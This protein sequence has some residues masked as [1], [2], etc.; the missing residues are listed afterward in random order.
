MKSLYKLNSM[1]NKKDKQLLLGLVFMTILLSLIEIIGIGAVMPFISIASNPNLVLENSHYKE[2]YDFFAFSNVTSFILFFGITLI[3][4][5]IFRG[6]YTIF[7]AYMLTKL[8]MGK[9]SSFSNKLFE[10]YMNMPYMEFAK[11]NSASLTKVIITEALQLSSMLRN[12]LILFSEL[13]IVVFLYIILLMID[14]N[15]TL[16]LTLLLG[17][18]IV[19]LIVT[20]TK[21][22]KVE[23]RKRASV[24]DNFYREISQMFGNFKIIKFI[25]NQTQLL[26]HFS[27]ISKNFT[28]VQVKN[29][30]LQAIPRSVLEAIG[31]SILI[32]IVIYIIYYEDDVS[33]VIPII[34]MYALALYR[35]LPAATKILKSYNNI[36]FYLSS[37][38]IVHNDLSVTYP[39]ER[40]ETINF[41]STIEINNVSFSYD[42]KNNVLEEISLVINK[43]SKVAFIG[44]SGSGKSTLVDLL[45]GIY[46]PNNGKVLID[47]KVLND[48][49]LVSWRKRIGYIPQDIYL[50][51]GTVS[52]NIVFGREYDE[53]KLMEVLKQANLYDFIVLNNGL[54][55]MVGDRGLQL[56]GGQKQRIGIARALYGKP[57]ILVLDEATSAL[58]NKTE[59]AI[60]NEIYK[61]SE[62]KTL[63]IIAHRLSTVEK[64]DYKIEIDKGKIVGK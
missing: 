63:I 56:S 43:G 2:V 33:R 4:F 49:N 20:V 34:S 31:L 46:K 32:G 60:M 28:N 36:V 64:C 51:D 47:S 6:I 53:N 26:N 37:L 55:S 42:N 1:L 45:C 5:Y 40:N 27:K 8:S 15:M 25:S 39:I 18:K 29:D 38:N 44:K 21:K 48:D 50:F 12:I 52:D 57:D 9:Y 35:I 13:L 30:T 59:T 19:F 24:Q 16:I 7:Y 3:V 23:G 11:K 41:E 61:A 62:N 17:I 54:S 14:F 22:I 10:N 58:D